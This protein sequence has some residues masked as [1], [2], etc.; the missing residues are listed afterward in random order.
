MEPVLI[1]W[2]ETMIFSQRSWGY[3][4]LILFSLWFTTLIYADEGMEDTRPSWESQRYLIEGVHY[5]VN[6]GDRDMAEEF[7]R[8]AIFSS[9]FGSLSGKDGA[10]ETSES[11]RWVASEVFYFLGKIQYERAVS[12]GAVPQN[13]A[14]AKRYLEKA[15]EYGVIHDRLHPPLLDEANRKYPRV[16]ALDAPLSE[17]SPDRAKIIVEIGH[18]AYEMDAVRVGQN[19]DVTESRFRTNKEFN[20]DCGA[21]YK[22]KPNIR[23]S[24]RSMYGAL[25]AVG[26]SLVIWLARG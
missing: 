12:Q 4:P 1:R 24:N 6:E 7:F 23:R 8:R 9:S 25:T 20:L 3:I 14:W 5:L 10:D 19:A 22:V 16:D 18:G 2:V 13:I 26:I 21:R 15:N 17:T 11:S